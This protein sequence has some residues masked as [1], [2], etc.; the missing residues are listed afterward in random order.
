M[1]G[2]IWWHLFG[3]LSIWVSDVEEN[4][5][6]LVAWEGREQLAASERT[7]TLYWMNERKR[8]SIPLGTCLHLPRF[9]SQIMDCL[10]LV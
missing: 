2:L 1:C 4:S 3:L 10:D 8:K 6:K 9:E 7:T 5:V